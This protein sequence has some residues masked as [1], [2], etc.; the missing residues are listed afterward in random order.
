MTANKNNISTVQ[1]LFIIIQ[2]QIGVGILWLPHEVALV[3]KHDGWISV[4]IGG[5]VIQIFVF[6]F[7]LLSKRFSSLTFFDILDSLLGKTFGKIIVFFYVVY[8]VLE[9]SAIVARYSQIIEKWILQITPTWITILLM[10]VIGVYIARGNLETI[11]RFFVLVSPLLIVFFLLITYALKDA[12]FLYL[13]PIGQAGIPVILEGSKETVFSYLG[14]NMFLFIYPFVKGTNKQKLK[15]LTAAQ[16]ITTL[17]YTYMVFASIAYFDGSTE[18]E[19]TKEPLLVMIKAYSFQI[20]DRPDLFFLSFWII[21]VATTFTFWIYVAATGA[22][23]LF[24]KNHNK[25]LP[26]VAIVTFLIALFPNEE[27]ALNTF[28]EYIGLL[29][30]LFSMIIPA[31]LLVLSL[32]LR[33]KESGV[34]QS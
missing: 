3:S 14:F 25:L 12:H 30:Y 7:W 29:S 19:L 28:N 34:N 22:A 23:H 4:F 8:F 21:S 17:F 18:M 26:Y 11:A 20:I 5:W 2:V 9:S 16:L 13:L 33:K 6:I 31:L 24:K 27:E 15:A 1:L 32:T 10:V